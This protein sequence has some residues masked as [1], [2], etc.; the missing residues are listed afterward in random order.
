MKLAL[1]LRIAA[2]PASYEY[3]MRPDVQIKMSGKEVHI[4]LKKKKER[5]K[6]EKQ[7]RA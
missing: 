4:V 5:K 2:K 7:K 3:N 1:T 6:K